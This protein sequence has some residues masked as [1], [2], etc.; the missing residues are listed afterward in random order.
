MT[1]SVGIAIILIL[2]YIAALLFKLVTHR[3]VYTKDAD[4]NV[5][6]QKSQNGVKARQ[7]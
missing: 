4:E 7:S 1:L 6:T 5:V 2:L 3:G